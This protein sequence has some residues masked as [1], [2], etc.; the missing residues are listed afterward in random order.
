MDNVLFINH[1]RF[2]CGVYQY[3]K[4]LTKSLEGC[5]K[6][7]IIYVE[8]EREEEFKELVVQY[9]PKCVV[10]NYY[11]G[12]MGF[13]NHPLLDSNRDNFPQVAIFHETPLTGFDY[14]IYSD[15]TLG[16]EKEFWDYYC[17]GR[18]YAEFGQDYLSKPEYFKIG[19]SIPYITN[20]F[21]VPEIPTIGT[22]GF[23][24]GGKDMHSL[25]GR[26]N[27]EFE[28]AIINIHL[29]P[30]TFSGSSEEVVMNLEKG[31]RDL[32]T[33][34]GI[35]LNITYEFLPE[36]RLLEFLARNTINVF[37]YGAN[38]GRG[39]SSSVDYALAVQRPIAITKSHMFR[40]M[41]PQ[42]P[43]ICLVESWKTLEYNTLPEIITLGTKPLKK[44]Y[45]T[46]TDENLVREFEEIMNGIIK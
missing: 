33:K 2:K 9:Q 14:Y 15:P 42:T 16:R 45:S 23:A 39:I 21:P 40:H 19:R 12:V 35:K 26:V 10:Y 37:W 28:E 43:E 11:P 24:G 32:I 25:V 41:W 18:G 3:G 8:I 31:C 34:P 46:W 13:V 17:P 1:I 44:F 5:Q 7:D 38:Y 29:A 6:Y 4:R 20:N 22:F 30:S 27:T 36:G